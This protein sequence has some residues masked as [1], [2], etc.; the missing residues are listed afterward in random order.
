VK[1]TLDDIDIYTAVRIDG[2]KVRTDGD[3]TTT[4]Q[5]LIRAF[6]ETATDSGWI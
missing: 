3:N 1:I 2:A 5:C 6:M 4:T